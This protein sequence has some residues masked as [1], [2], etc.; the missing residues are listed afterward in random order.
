MRL[1]AILLAVLC[2]NSLGLQA[3]GQSANVI[4]PGE[5]RFTFAFGGF[6]TGFD[7]DLRIDNSGVG[8]RFNL[9]DDLGVE[10][11]QTGVWAGAEWRFFRRHRIGVNYTRFTPSAERTVTRSIQIGEV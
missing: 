3:A 6:L 9:K 11:Q 8:T 10:R 4:G 2:I 7:A 5:E 1:P